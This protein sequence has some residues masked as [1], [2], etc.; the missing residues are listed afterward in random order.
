MK[1]IKNFI[2]YNESLTNAVSLIDKSMRESEIRGSI[3]TL[4]ELIEE[5]ERHEFIE[6]N[7]L[8]KFVIEDIAS[9]KIKELEE[10]LKDFKNK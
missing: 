6:N 5:S 10:E 8:V 4:K 9:K 3:K 2:K 7:K 1:K